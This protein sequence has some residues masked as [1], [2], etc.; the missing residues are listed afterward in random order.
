MR[1]PKIKFVV[2]NNAVDYSGA[3]L[4]VQVNYVYTNVI[5]PVTL[6]ECETWFLAIKENTLRILEEDT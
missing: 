4:Y 3:Q 6:F 1:T 2:I 5:L